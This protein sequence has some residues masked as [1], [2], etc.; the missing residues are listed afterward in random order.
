MFA[1]YTVVSAS[2]YFIV[3]AYY[4]VFSRVIAGLATGALTPVAIALIIE[5]YRDDAKRSELY[6]GFYNG[7]MGLTGCVIT[8]GAGL[9]MGAGLVR[10][11]VEG[12]RAVFSENFAAIPI[13]ILMIITLPK[14]LAEK[15][16][17]YEQSG[18][19]S[20]AIEDAAFPTAKAIAIMFS[21]LMASLLGN[22]INYQY[23]IY[24]AENFTI[25]PAMYGPI[26]ATIAISSTFAG[27]LFG[28]IIG[29]AKRF[30]ITIAYAMLT[31]GYTALRFPL[32]I[33]WVLAGLAVNGFAFGIALPY[34]Y[35]YARAL[36]PARSRYTSLFTSLITVT[37]GIGGFLCTFSTTFLQSILNLSTVT[38]ILPYISGITGIGAMLSI[39]LGIRSVRSTSKAI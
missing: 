24:L 6:I 18:P 20:K 33:P 10:G 39:I 15:N 34:F 2:P 37:V 1:V 27:L 16:V 23:A 32:G 26:G 35:S 3:N 7:A 8:I 13:L 5:I 21:C 9:L 11:P 28:I 25:D 12:I 14:T 22:I 19:G 31:L 17:A 30:T 36:F 38:S 4:I 29:H